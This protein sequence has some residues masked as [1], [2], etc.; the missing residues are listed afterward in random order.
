M[1]LYYGASDDLVQELTYDSA[2]KVWQ[3]EFSFAMSNGNSGIGIFR[4]GLTD[5]MIYLNSAYQI[6][7]W[8]KD[9]NSSNVVSSAHPVGLWTR[10]L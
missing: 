6:E 8:W 1:R 7:I 3:S 9:S 4:R 5:Y 10:G 2:N